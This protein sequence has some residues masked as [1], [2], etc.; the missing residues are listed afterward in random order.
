[1]QLSI[2]FVMAWQYPIDPEVLRIPPRHPN[3]K[4]ETRNPE[5]LKPGNLNLLP[6]RPKPFVTSSPDYADVTLIS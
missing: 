1:M 6:S 5:T 4:P 3:P 2:V